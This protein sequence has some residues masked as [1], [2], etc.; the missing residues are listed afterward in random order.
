MK[1]YIF[2]LLA[3]LIWGLLPA[4]WKLLSSL[5][6]AE[7]LAH[8]VI[9]SVLF[10]AIIVQFLGR[11]RAVRQTLQQPMTG[12]AVTSSAILI[13]AN[14]LVFIWAVNAG[15]LLE[16]SLGYFITPLV[17]LLFGVTLLKERLSFGQ[18]VAVILAAFGVSYMAY[19]FGA[20]PWISL[21][22]AFTFAGYGLLR[23]V[24]KVS[25]LD[26]LLLET[27]MLFPVALG[28]IFFLESSGVGKTFALDSFTFM[29]L[30]LCGVATAVPLLL[31]VAAAKLLPFTTIGL[32]QYSAPTIQLLMAV[33]IFD[34]P[35][36]T[37]H[38]VA[39]SFIWSALAL[40]SGESFRL[41]R[42]TIRLATPAQSP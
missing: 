34:E 1:G 7:I 5:P 30:V 19:D 37:V 31:Y 6:A 38:L 12:F 29:L 15:F 25:S 3:F 21:A 9:W 27:A 23:K 28:Y 32:L 2:G 17:N 16:C 10:L 41:H 26:G 33:V 22:L 35:F 8:R 24:A 18:G 20:L 39:F 40:Y 42:Q 36:T 13:G 11:W 14:W 4:Y